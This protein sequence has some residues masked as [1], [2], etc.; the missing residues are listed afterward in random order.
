MLNEVSAFCLSCLLN[1]LHYLSLF[2]DYGRKKRVALRQ[3]VI[4]ALNTTDV[5]G[6]Y[7]RAVDL[8]N[9]HLAKR[10]KRIR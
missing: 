9:N 8:E 10:Q 5:L 2:R 4:K 7:D 1:V 3:S 6:K